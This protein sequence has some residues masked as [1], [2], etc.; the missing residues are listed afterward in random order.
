MNLEL[1]VIGNGAIAVMVDEHARIVW[2]CFPRLDADPVFCALLR[3]THPTQES[4]QDERGLFAVE[5]AGL[6]HTSQEYLTNTAVLS[7][8]LFASDGSAIDVV[9]FVPRYTQYERMFRPPTL[10]RRMSPLAGN[11]RIRVR[12]TPLFAWGQR[13][14][15]ITLGSNHI[16]YVSDSSALRLTTD[17]ALSYIVEEQTFILERPLH[18]IFG[19]DEGLRAGIEE[20]ARM[21]LER[22]LAYWRDWVRSLSI[23]CDWQQEVIRAAITLKLCNF[24]ETGAIVAAL[25]TSIPEAPGSQRNWDYRYCWPRDAYF[26][27]HA[28]NRLGATRTMEDYLCYITNIA[29]ESGDGHLR[30]LYGITRSAPLD[31]TIAEALTGYRGMGPV[32]V[33]NQAHQQVQ[34]DVY[35]SVILAATHVFFD[36]RLVRS[37]NIPLFEKLEVLG[38]R[39]RTC[40]DQPDAGPWELRNK[41]AV[42]TFSSL[43]CWAACDR[44]AKIARVLG[45]EERESWWRGEADRMQNVI[46]NRCW[47]DDINSY[48]STWDGHDLDA[49]LLL[50]HEINFIDAQHPRF[51]STVAAIGQS[52]RRGNMLLRYTVEDDFGSPETAFTICTFWYIDAL[53]SLGHTAEARKLFEDLLQRRTALGLLSEDIHPESGELWGNFPQAYSMVGLINSAMRLSRSWEEAF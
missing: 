49:S 35:G 29:A 46:N 50:M 20:T 25:T 10:V 21:F 32:R 15:R 19:T 16:R 11:P 43:I 9:D 18:F 13:T 14:P 31:E 51:A 42:H 28:L 30:P 7:T 39:A 48:V 47:N 41:P 4:P 17:A 24:E 52:L 40:F 53:A 23:P 27:V 3:G 1:G 44:L 5:L 37:G 6:S 36:Q 26:V 34:H 33:G 38:H 12:L 45:M 22:T 8:K 2:G